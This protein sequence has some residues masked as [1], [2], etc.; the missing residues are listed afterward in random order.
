MFRRRR[1][2][3]LALVACLQLILG[4]AFAPP[5]TSMPASSLAHMT[6]HHHGATSGSHGRQQTHDPCHAECCD[7]C[8]ACAACV[9]VPVT[10]VAFVPPVSAPRFR[11]AIADDE[12]L[13]DRPTPR[14]YP[15]PLGPPVSRV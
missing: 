5:S 4:L 8:A 2:R 9:V 15:P 7:N 6:A 3:F 11:S 13:R 1:S 10:S 12:P 14:L